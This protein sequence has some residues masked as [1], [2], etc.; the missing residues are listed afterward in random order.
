MIFHGRGREERIMACGPGTFKWFF[1]CVQLHVVVQSP[2]LS[3]TSIAE[4]AGEFPIRAKKK[5]KKA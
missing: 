5:T 4:L 1:A 3:K 2:S